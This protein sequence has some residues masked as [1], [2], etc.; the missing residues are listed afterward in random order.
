M[1]L[2]RQLARAAV[3]ARTAASADAGSRRGFSQCAGRRAE[4]EITI[5]GK[6]VKIEQV[7]QFPFLFLL[8]FVLV[9]GGGFFL[10]GR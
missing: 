1:M 10:G 2:R 8:Y 6:K 7:R 5:D 4:V 3:T 9:Q